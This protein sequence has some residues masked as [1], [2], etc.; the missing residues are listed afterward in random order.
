[1]KRCNDFLLMPSLT[2][3][4][5]IVDMI[6]QSAGLGGTYSVRG[7]VEPYRYR[8]M[9]DAISINL[10]AFEYRTRAILPILTSRFSDHNLS[11]VSS[12]S[13]LTV[14]PAH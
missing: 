2:L 5:G 14:V 9:Q 4:A 3:E 8:Q 11:L 13:T 7:N 6:R 12:L 1:M 10:S